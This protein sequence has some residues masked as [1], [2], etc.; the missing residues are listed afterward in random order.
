MLLC[1]GLCW[2]C[3]N[4]TTDRTTDDTRLQREDQSITATNDEQ[5][6]CFIRLD[7]DQQQDSTYLQLVIRG[8]TVSGTYNYLPYEKDARRGTV[9]GTADNDTL[10]MVWTYKQEGI[11]DTMRV[12]FLLEGEKLLQKS[13]TIDTLTGRQFTLD[14][15]GFSEIYEQIDCLK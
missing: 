12:V 5:K 3:Q 9:L 14:T 8:E 6:H 10:D 15:D 11:Q 4:E 13:L 1:A 2:T 7:G